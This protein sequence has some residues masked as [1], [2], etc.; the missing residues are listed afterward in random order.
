[1][2]TWCG[3]MAYTAPEVLLQ[4]PYK[5]TLADIWALGVILYMIVCGHHPFRQATESET[6]AKV[7]DIQYE[8]PDHVSEDFKDLVGRIIQRE[9]S[10]RATLQEIMSHPWLCDEAGTV[11]VLQADV[12]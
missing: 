5:G 4:E 1:M 7:M 12:G 6:L 9:P 10:D 3:S 11:L 2:D 8:F